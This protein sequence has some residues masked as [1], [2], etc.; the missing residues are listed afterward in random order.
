MTLLLSSAC[1]ADMRNTR[2]GTQQLTGSFADT[3]ASPWLQ[4]SDIAAAN[5]GMAGDRIV[6]DKSIA[7]RHVDGKCRLSFACEH[8]VTVLDSVAHR[9]MY[10][11]F[12]KMMEKMQPRRP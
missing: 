4:Q 8:Q 12:V 9:R 10:V 5:G 11:A 2:L 3:L 6:E 1:C 7:S